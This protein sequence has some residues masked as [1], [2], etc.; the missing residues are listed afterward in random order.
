MSLMF[1]KVKYSM[2]VNIKTKILFNKNS[3]TVHFVINGL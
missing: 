3:F 2:V 1:R